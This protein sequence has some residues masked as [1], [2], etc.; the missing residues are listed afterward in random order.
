MYL[1][2]EIWWSTKKLEKSKFLLP[3]WM[4]LTKIAGSV[5]RSV[6]QSRG[7]LR[8]SGSGS[9][10]KFQWSAAM[11]HHLLTLYS[12]PLYRIGNI[13]ASINGFY[14]ISIR[15]RTRFRIP[16]PDP[17]C[18]SDPDC[19]RIQMGYHMYMATTGFYVRK[20]MLQVVVENGKTMYDSCR[21][22]LPQRYRI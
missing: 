20:K 1:Q 11:P 14:F 6:S 7:T 18:V 3:S 5:A 21:Y 4:S 17:T 2:K 15:K 13:F 22:L 8:I 9:V 12:Y 16:H 10:S 19:I